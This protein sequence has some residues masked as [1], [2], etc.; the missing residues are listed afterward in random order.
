MGLMGGHRQ[1]RAKLS[2][3]KLQPPSGCLLQKR[4]SLHGMVL[5]ECESQAVAS[6]CPQE[7]GLFDV[8]GY[9][10]LSP[11]LMAQLLQMLAAEW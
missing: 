5:V 8:Y 9:Q 6:L 11:Y 10:K 3:V 7:R 2:I 4:S 1:H